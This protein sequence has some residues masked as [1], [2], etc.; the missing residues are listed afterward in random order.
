MA[1]LVAR[2]RY[3]ADAAS[4]FSLEAG[5]LREAADTIAAQAAELEGVRKDAA[6]ARAVLVQCARKIKAYQSEYG[7]AYVGGQEASS[8]LR[9]IDTAI[10]DSG[11]GGG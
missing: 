10:A 4:E 2:L 5:L 9:D 8:L 3:R 11:A 1:D 7:M 6:E